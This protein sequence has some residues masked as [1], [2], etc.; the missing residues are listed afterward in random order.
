MSDYVL[1]L[2]CSGETYSVGLLG[3]RGA[4]AQVQGYL[5]RRALKEMTGAVSHLLASQGVEPTQLSRVGVTRGPGSF[6]GVR[7]GV[8]LARTA[9]LVAGCPAVGVDTLKVLAHG[10]GLTAVALDARRSEVYCGLFHD[11]QVLIPT[12]VRSPEEFAGLL[13]EH[14]PL[15]LVGA[16]FEVYPEMASAPVTLTD[17]VGAAPSGLTVARMALLLEPEEGPLQPHYFRRADIQV[18]R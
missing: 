6:T 9:A 14:Q 17:R 11:E 4:C 1:G 7:L 12:D 10:R 16:G 8:T 2:D 3:P 13:A 18:S 15:T 5:A